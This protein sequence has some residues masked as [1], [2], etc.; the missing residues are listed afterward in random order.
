MNRCNMIEIK[1]TFEEVEKAI[2]FLSSIN[3]K[4]VES[5]R[6]DV[7]DEINKNIKSKKIEKPEKPKASDDLEISEKAEV[8]EAS[9]KLAFFE[10]QKSS[11]SKKESADSEVDQKTLIA[12]FTEVGKKKG[13]ESI[14]SILGKL[15]ATSVLG[16]PGVGIAKEDW[17]R[18]VELCKEELGIPF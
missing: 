3:G 7:S 9:E 5:S 11:E 17:K 16:P 1:F 15:N 2:E 12:T 8:S 6:I 18:A 13:R 4:K 14:V 10:E